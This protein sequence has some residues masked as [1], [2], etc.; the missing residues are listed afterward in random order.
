MVFIFENVEN[1]IVCLFGVMAS[2]VFVVIMLLMLFI[3][4]SLLIKY[5][6]LDILI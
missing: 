4:N 2:F 5:D 3:C 1:F 6:N